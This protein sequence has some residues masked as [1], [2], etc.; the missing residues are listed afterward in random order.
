MQQ[1]Y[2]GGAVP[3]CRAFVSFVPLMTAKREHPV[4]AT[5]VNDGL[6]PGD[7]QTALDSVLEL[8]LYFTENQQTLAVDE[9]LPGD[10]LP[11]LYGGGWLYRHGG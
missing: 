8:V 2:T 1:S 9:L 4:A 7:Q 5:L 6:L 11:A 3:R 10:G